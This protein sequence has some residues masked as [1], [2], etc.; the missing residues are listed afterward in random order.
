M[1]D[2]EYLWPILFSMFLNK[3]KERDMVDVKAVIKNDKFGNIEVTRCDGGEILLKNEKSSFIVNGRDLIQAII[4]VGGLVENFP[5]NNST[6]N[7]D[8]R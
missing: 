5:F 3:E 4:A 8:K 2:A 6:T 1:N 7:L